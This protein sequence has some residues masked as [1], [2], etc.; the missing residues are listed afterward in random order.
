MCVSV[1]YVNIV[2]D[3]FHSKKKWEA[4][5]IMYTSLQV[6]HT[7]FLCQIFIKV[8]SYP[9]FWKRPQIPNYKEI[10]PVGTGLFYADGQTDRHDEANRHFSQFCEG[11]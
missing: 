9:D 8:E 4:Q 6:K 3:I 10:R 5:S 7:S 11:A 2:W 1:V